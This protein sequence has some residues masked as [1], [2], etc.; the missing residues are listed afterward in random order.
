M[1][2][3]RTSGRPLRGCRRLTLQVP[4]SSFRGSAGRSWWRHL[5]SAPGPRYG[6]RRHQPRARPRSRWPWGCWSSRSSASSAAKVNP[7]GRVAFQGGHD[8]DLPDDHQEGLDGIGEVCL[9]DIAVE[10]GG[11]RLT[12]LGVG[13]EQV[14]QARVAFQATVAPGHLDRVAVRAAVHREGHA[15]FCTSSTPW[16]SWLP[17][18]AVGLAAGGYPACGSTV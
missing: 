16:G 6:M 11:D 2:T 4:W 1:V 7:W 15:R 14:D 8:R 12:G 9:H 18:V 5:V 10:G 17:R 3:C 13:L